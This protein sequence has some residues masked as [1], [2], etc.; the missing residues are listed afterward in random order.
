MKNIVLIKVLLLRYWSKKTVVHPSFANTINTEIKLNANVSKL[1]AGTLLSS[2]TF[3]LLGAK[4]G[5]G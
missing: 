2:L 3:A 1:E 4:Y 5:M